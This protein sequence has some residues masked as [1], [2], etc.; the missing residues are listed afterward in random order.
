ME[1]PEL[2]YE[3]EDY[4]LHETYSTVY[5]PKSEDNIKVCENQETRR[6]SDS[7]EAYVSG[8]TKKSGPKM[9][10][11]CHCTMNCFKKVGLENAKIIFQNF[12]EMRNNKA[13]THYII[14]RMSGFDTIGN[15]SY[16]NNKK[17]HYT[18]L[19]KEKSINVCRKAFLGIHGIS[20]YK[21]K[22]LLRKRLKSGTCNGNQRGKHKRSNSGKKKVNIFIRN[23][24]KNLPT[25]TSHYSKRKLQKHNVYLPPG[26]SIE[27]IYSDYLA[28]LEREKK[29][30]LKASMLMYSKVFK[31]EFNI[32]FKPP[33]LETCNFCDYKDIELKT[34]NPI[35]DASRIREKTLEKQNHL[36][37][38][39]TIHKHMRACQNDR[40]SSLAAIAI[41]LPSTFPTPCL[42][43]GLHCTTKLLT[44]NLCIYNLKNK[45]AY[46]YVW[47]EADGKRGS[48]ETASCMLHF[49]ENFIDESV[50]KLVVFSENCSSQSKNI[51][52]VLYYLRLIQKERF[53]FVQH[54]YMDPG[55]SFL[56]CYKDFDNL[57]L[58]IRGQN[59]YS[60]A[61]YIEFLKNCK[62]KNIFNV[63]EMKCESFF[64]F[65]CLRGRVNLLEYVEYGFK[66][67]TILIVSEDYKMGFKIKFQFESD[68]PVHV[69]LQKGSG[70]EYDSSKMNLAAIKLPLKYPQGI[71][72]NSAK[73]NGL[74]D[75]CKFVP[76]PYQ[77]FYKEILQ[78]SKLH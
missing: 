41:D 57:E 74:K 38:A 69:K 63:I 55:H 7:V 26:S 36:D 27:T 19:V 62:T 4:N 14:S 39:K 5:L 76:H 1:E 18:V 33:K 30:H 61:H 66:A 44:Y 8:T 6:E 73:L 78:K 75:L 42:R 60:T 53:N 28:Y 65:D 48:S 54:Y 9:G 2:D 31:T 37:S 45:N 71:K 29:K 43:A 24:I 17:K 47:N 59:V 20:D 25:C 70:D 16:E 10:K 21:V 23:H 12:W 68:T 56:P 58:S 52:I 49:V 32:R 35:T 15:R 22:N 3:D 13:Q 64:D 51:N 67:A 50:K 77:S 72:L 46:F 11:P 34:L 40:D